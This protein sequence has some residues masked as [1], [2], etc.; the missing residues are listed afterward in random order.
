MAGRRGSAAATSGGKGG[1]RGASHRSNL[2][3]PREAPGGPPYSKVGRAPTTFD[4]ETVV[5]G[6]VGRP[7]GVRGE[8][9]LR[10]HN[11][12]SRSFEGLRTLLLVRNGTSA[13][14]EIS[15]L[16]VVPDG[17]IA[18]LAGVDDREGAAALTLA[19]VRAP[20]ASLPPLAPGEYYVSD[21]VGCAV[22]REDGAPLGRV[23][24]T[25]WNGAQD[26]MI[27]EGD[28]ERGEQLIPLVPDFIVTVD[29]PGRRIVV[30]WE[31]H[32]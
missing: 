5:L 11:A 27:V 32:D 21:V 13:K 16:R 17:A 12:Q 3:S 6:V 10:P 15:S 22:E 7:H 26:V 28:P 9:W 18:K 25:F 31:G 20:R 29:A 2:E 4:P 23:T 1:R 24:S 14:Y 8:V 30:S 19:E